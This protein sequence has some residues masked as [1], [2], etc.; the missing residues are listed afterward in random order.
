[1]YNLTRRAVLTGVDGVVFVADS[2][3]GKMEENIESLNDL[4]E[5]LGYYK[6]DLESV[7]FILQYN[8]RDLD[9]LMPVEEM[10]EKLNAFMVPSFSASAINGDGVMETL[11]M[12]CKLVLKQIKDKTGVK[13]PKSTD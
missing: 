5:N 13:S 10:D 12:C 11:T 4:K 3:E 1:M 6:K 7:P 9:A 2:Q 8:K